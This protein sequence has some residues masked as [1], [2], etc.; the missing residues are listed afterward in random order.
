MTYRSVENP[1]THCAT[2]LEDNVLGAVY[3]IT[4]DFNAYF[5]KKYVTT[6]RWPISP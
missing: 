1:I 5:D 4:L 6:W 3:K 2:L